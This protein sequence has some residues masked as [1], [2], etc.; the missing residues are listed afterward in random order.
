MGNIDDSLWVN[1]EPA[2]MR[3]NGKGA[4]ELPVARKPLDA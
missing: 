4:E 1:G 3:L 2:G